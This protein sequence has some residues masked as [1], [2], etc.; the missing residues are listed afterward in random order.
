VA[1]CHLVTGHVEAAVPSLD[2]ALALFEYATT[3]TDRGWAAYARSHRGAAA[4]VQGR[5]E[6]GVAF[7]EGAAAQ[8]RAAGSDG[9]LLFVLGDFA[10]WLAD[11]GEVASARGLVGTALALVADH[12]GGW[13]AAGPLTSLA[14]V[15]ALEGHGE[16]AAAELGAVAAIRDRAG[17]DVPP[18]FQGRIARAAALAAAALGQA[19]YEAAWRRGQAA[20][21]DVLAKARARVPADR[22]AVEVRQRQGGGYA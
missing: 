20:P 3:S 8:A 19:S 18:H 7:Y 13:L 14:L 16:Q 1:C 17:L 22:E 21:G 6:E 4:F 2:R 10:G 11:L 5:A 12:P 15:D 9:V